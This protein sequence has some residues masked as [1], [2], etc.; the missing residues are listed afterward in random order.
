MKKKCF[1]HTSTCL[2]VDFKRLKWE[3]S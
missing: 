3:R 1:L 2:A